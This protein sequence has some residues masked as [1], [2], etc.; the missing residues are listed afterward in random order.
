[1][2]GGFEVGADLFGLAGGF[3]G[4]LDDGAGFEEVFDGDERE[5]FAEVVGCDGVFTK[6]C[7]VFW[8]HEAFE[9]L[10]WALENARQEGSV[11]WRE[12]RRVGALN[13]TVPLAFASVSTEGD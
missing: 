10:G 6:E 9:I 11:S 13:Q 5:D 8:E 7:V 2:D 4:L 3:D 1:V 12:V